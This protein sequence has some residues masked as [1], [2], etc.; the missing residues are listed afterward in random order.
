MGV[1]SVLLAFP[2]GGWRK[3]REHLMLKALQKRGERWRRGV[4]RGDMRVCSS[5]ID[6]GNL[7]I[8]LISQNNTHTVQCIYMKYVSIGRYRVKRYIII[9]VKKGYD[10]KKKRGRCFRFRMKSVVYE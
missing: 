1:W 10:D 6:Q 5:G 7:A 2:L 8:K 3:L 4:K 9:V